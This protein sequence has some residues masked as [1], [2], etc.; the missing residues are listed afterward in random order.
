[1]KPGTAAKVMTAKPH[2]SLKDS[3]KGKMTVIILAMAHT[4][5]AENSL[6]IAV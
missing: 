2:L 1:L 6:C 3:S 4:H 5:K